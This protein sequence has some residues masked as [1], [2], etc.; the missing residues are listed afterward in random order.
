MVSPLDLSKHLAR[1][2]RLEGDWHLSSSCHPSSI[3]VI[4]RGT[5]A[6][7]RLDWAYRG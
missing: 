2:D 6:A 7:L 1:L 3:R 5:F 4:K